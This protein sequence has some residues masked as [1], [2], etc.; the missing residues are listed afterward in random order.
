MITIMGLNPD[1]I[2]YMMAGKNST[3]NHFEWFVSFAYASRQI[4]TGTHSGFRR[5]R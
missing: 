5:I 1:N 2:I 3:V 4:R